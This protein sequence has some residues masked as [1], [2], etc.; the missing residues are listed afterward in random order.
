MLCT[1]QETA[2]EDCLNSVSISQHLVNIIDCIFHA[3]LSLVG[4][5]KTNEFLH[6]FTCNSTQAVSSNC[7]SNSMSGRVSFF[8]CLNFP[9]I[10]DCNFVL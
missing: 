7:D 1:S 9:Y 4:V 10:N 2:W 3:E 5:Y 6:V 8:I